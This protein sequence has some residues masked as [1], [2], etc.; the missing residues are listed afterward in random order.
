MKEDKMKMYYWKITFDNGT[1]EYWQSKRSTYNFVNMAGDYPLKIKKAEP[2]SKLVYLF[3]KRRQH[4][5]V[6]LQ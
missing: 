5:T 6:T 1:I 4:F 3:H 2:I